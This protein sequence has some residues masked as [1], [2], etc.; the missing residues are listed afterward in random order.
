MA[1]NPNCEEVRAHTVTHQFDMNQLGVAMAR[2]TRMSPSSTCQVKKLES[3]LTGQFNLTNI[4][5][6]HLRTCKGMPEHLRLQQHRQ[7]MLHKNLKY[8]YKIT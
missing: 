1:I 4:R 3:S 5:L 6:I 2:T 7:V 8:K